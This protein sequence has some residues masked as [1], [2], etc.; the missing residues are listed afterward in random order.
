MA[1]TE[2]DVYVLRTNEGFVIRCMVQLAIAA[3]DILVE[4]DTVPH[5]KQRAIWS[6]RVVKDPRPV[7]EEMFW[8]I[9]G[10]NNVYIKADVPDTITQANLKAAVTAAIDGLVRD[11]S[12]L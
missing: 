8:A 11:L 7:V 4:A 2:Q 12:A 10:H 9:A 5:Y 3:A 6:R 1:V